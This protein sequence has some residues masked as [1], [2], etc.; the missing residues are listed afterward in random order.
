MIALASLALLVSACRRQADEA[1]DKTHANTPPRAATPNPDNELR[2]PEG[3]SLPVVESAEP[4]RARAVVLLRDGRVH[5]QIANKSPDFPEQGVELAAILR[6]PQKN[7]L[8]EAFAEFALD[9]E[10]IALAATPDTKLTEIAKVWAALEERKDR[11]GRIRRVDLAVAKQAGAAKLDAAL[12]LTFMLP[13]PTPPR[14]GDASALAMTSISLGFGP[15][16]I[17]VSAIWPDLDHSLE[18][19]ERGPDELDH[20]GAKLDE[21]RAKLEADPSKLT[22]V[23]VYVDGEQELDGILPGYERVRAA[24]ETDHLGMALYAPPIANNDELEQVLET[25][26]GRMKSAHDE[27]SAKDPPAED[28]ASEP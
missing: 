23:T 3:W 25:M 27:A 26:V 6:Q 18:S 19:I 4:L 17:L 13:P 2:V 12:P 28:P 20:L 14:E 1:E 16:R 7:P 5:L 15:E 21:L 10:D 22:W 24:L 9:E 11:P 8:D